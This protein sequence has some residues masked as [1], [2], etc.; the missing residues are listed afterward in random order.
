M[1]V[2]LEPAR[3]VGNADELKQLK[4]ACARLSV[5]HV[6]VNLQRFHHLLADRKDRIERGHRLLENHRDVAAALL[7]HLLFG[8]LEQVLSFKQDLPLGDPAGLGEQ[9]HDRERRDRLAA[10]GFPDHGDDLAAIDRIG[11][12]FH[13]ADRAA[14]GLEPHMQVAHLEQGRGRSGLR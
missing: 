14:R 13:C 3:P 7:A 1:W 11:D 2:L 6:Q 9:A 12:A 4:R 8:K 5:G 10:A